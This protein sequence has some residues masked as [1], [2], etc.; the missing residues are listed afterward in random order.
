M[1]FFLI[2]GAVVL[3]VGILLV[4][5]FKPGTTSTPSVFG[6]PVSTLSQ[7]GGAVG[8]L[9]QNVTASN[10]AS[11]AAGAGGNAIGGVTKASA[12]AGSTVAP[13]Q[14]DT[15]ADSDV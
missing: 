14:G 9:I 3:G 11:A 7:A 10:A 6:I 5:L 12:S 2:G 15:Y 4:E 13:T 8:G 1:P